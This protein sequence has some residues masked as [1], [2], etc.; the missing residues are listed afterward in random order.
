MQGGDILRLLKNNLK[1]KCLTIHVNEQQHLSYWKLVNKKE[2]VVI[3]PQTG[4]RSSTIQNYRG[5]YFYHMYYYAIFKEHSQL[6]RKLQPK[7][8]QI[9]L[10]RL[11]V[12]K[13]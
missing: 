6:L 3:V 7:G 2:S 11:S 4:S 1:E 5:L 9:A 8:F 13:F 12:T 10:N